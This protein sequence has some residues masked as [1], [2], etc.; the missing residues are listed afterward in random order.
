MM[1][2]KWS[3]AL[4]AG[5]FLVLAL[6]MGCKDLFHPE[7]PKETPG[8]ENPTETPGKEDPTETPGN[9][10][11]SPTPP[12]NISA[13]A[14][15]TSSIRITWDPAKTETSYKVYRATNDPESTS[16]YTSIGT[17]ETV[18]FTDTAL[19]T[20]T[21]YYYRLASVK[22][23]LESTLSPEYASA[24]PQAILLAVP[25]GLTAV[26][27]SKNSIKVAWDSVPDALGYSIYQ[28]SS[29]EAAG[30][31]LDTTAATDYTVIGL[32]ANTMYYFRVSAF[33]LSIETS[34]SAA[35]P[36]R[37]SGI[38]GN[39]GGINGPF[40]APANL[41]ATADSSSQIAVGWDPV[42]GAGF[43]EVYRAASSDGPYTL[44]SSS[45]ITENTYIDTGLAG[46]TGY[47]YKVRAYTADG[48]KSSNLSST[49]F[50]TTQ[51]LPPNTP[52]ITLGSSELM[53]SW[54]SVTGASAYEVWAGTSSNSAD[55]AKCGDDTSSLSAV[56]SGL[57]NGT[58]YYIWIKAKNS[59]GTTI[60]SPVVSGMPIAIPGTPSIIHGSSQLT[61]SWAAVTGAS[62]YEVWAGVSD[63]SAEAAKR[64]DDT[65][66]LSA[67]ISGLDNGTTYYI[68]I[69]AKNGT[70]T[71]SFSPVASGMPIAI[72]ETPSITLGSSELTVS[73][74]SVTGA[75]A[76]EVWAGTSSNSAEAAKRGEDTSS[77]S[78]VIS[79]LENG[80]TYYMWIKAKNS[81]GTGSFSPVASGKP[82]AIP[83]T[84]SI[85][86]GNRELAV[87]WTA[88]DGAEL[89][90]VYYGIGT[91]SILA[92]TVSGT[93]AT[94]SG[95][96]NGTIYSVAI[97]GMNTTGSGGIS[98]TA[99]GKPTI[100][101]GLY[102][103]T[104]DTSHKIGAVSGLTS[105]L[106]HIST[107]AITD[108]NYF[109]V[110]GADES[111]SNITLSQAGL[112]VCI[113][114]VGDNAE[115][116]ISLNA[117][118]NL[119]TVKAGVTLILENNITLQVRSTNTQSLVKV[120]TGGTLKMNDGVKIRGN[121]AS[122]SSSGGGVSVTGGTFTMSGGEIS[123]NTASSSY[124]SYGGGVSVTGGIFTKS[125]GCII[126]GS[127][128]SA[129]LKNTAYSVSSGHAVYAGSSKIRNTTVG[130]G[131]ELDSSKSGAAGGWVE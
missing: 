25:S 65:S 104:I 70:G 90:E 22:N 19:T 91:P 96:I 72:L 59:T 11:D 95:L 46:G 88:T 28:G 8:K 103:D 131:V 110:L 121:K 119:F 80:T 52:T 35:I 31:L 98:G 16:S 74:A 111:V 77:V 47:Y 33:D 68:W 107:Y 61:V 118:T 7:G 125:T 79:G 18:T 126:Y 55:A 40:L 24:V 99:T 81:T 86:A 29:D 62:A 17:T 49:V 13:K 116:T 53:V 36:A 41:T 115:R 51:T 105:S 21:T 106:N 93:S 127:N 97:R 1:N 71:G 48:T 109:I 122:S 128:A 83:V 64:G 14:L 57:D 75:S 38:D 27:L 117:N 60:F 2:R 120:E 84:P 94:I 6:L 63:N 92:A 37:T 129:E 130:V 123:G 50:A 113:T 67:V 30:D 73:W 4:F 3:V 45:V 76:Y 20:G 102:K 54:A 23:N 9:D 124:Y 108:D 101:P 112:P 82:I 69:K 85:V 39:A 43:Y 42:T 78:A 66:S 58:T 5:I 26:I 87:S 34:P 56:I 32:S 89:Y 114:L 44:I 15:S 100:A 10:D 12:V